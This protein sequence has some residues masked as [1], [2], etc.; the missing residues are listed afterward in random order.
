M[1][2][3]FFLLLTT[4]SALPSAE[5]EP[6]ANAEPQLYGGLAGVPQRFDSGGL[7][8]GEGGQGYFPGGAG[9]A[10]VVEPG[11]VWGG[12]VPQGDQCG[13]MDQC[14]GRWRCL[15]WKLVHFGCRHGRARLLPGAGSEVLHSVRAE[16]Q[17]NKKSRIFLCIHQVRQ[18]AGLPDDDEGILRHLS[19]QT[20]SLH[21]N[22]RVKI[23]PGEGLPHEDREQMLGV[24]G[25]W[26]W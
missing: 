11:S 6:D 25:S 17:V 5:P 10:S 7:Q 16:M 20:V 21:Q 8:P 9:G 26:V 1:I 15:R 4:T 14:C 13:M 24:W 19:D 12:G 18:Q 23:Y 22:S 3:R 2:L